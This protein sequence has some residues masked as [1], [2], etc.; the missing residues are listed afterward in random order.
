MGPSVDCGVGVDS[1]I[2]SFTKIPRMFILGDGLE[3]IYH[4]CSGMDD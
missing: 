1:Y 3:S 4:V 2:F